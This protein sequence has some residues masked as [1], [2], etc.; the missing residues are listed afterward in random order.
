MMR[1]LRIGIG[2]KNGF[3]TSDY[4]AALELGMANTIF[5][6]WIL[7]GDMRR[8]EADDKTM[9]A[10]PTPPAEDFWSH[11]PP[12]DRLLTQFA[13]DQNVSFIG[14]VPQ[15]ARL[16]T[17]ITGRKSAG[18]YLS[19][20]QTEL[21]LM[22]KWRGGLLLFNTPLWFY[23]D[24]AQYP[25]SIVKQ[26]RKSKE[27]AS[28]RP[29]AFQDIADAVVTLSDVQMKRLAKEFPH[30]ESNKAKRPLFALY[31]KYPNILGGEGAV[32]D[33]NMVSVMEQLKVMPPIAS[34]ETLTRIRVLEQDNPQFKDDR[35]SYDVQVQTMQHHDWQ[36]VGI[37]TIF[38]GERKSASPQ[39]PGT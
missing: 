12:V 34:K 29:L 37:V 16:G 7:P 8:A 10:L 32:V 20:L 36:N 31:K 11:A 19:V 3:M 18:Q 35:R 25:Y 39:K 9:N 14:I 22:H 24:E 4:L 13:E 27:D 33:L 5:E 15:E 2:N 30:E 17:E 26:L 28:G 38:P 6:R 1:N 23:G 21:G